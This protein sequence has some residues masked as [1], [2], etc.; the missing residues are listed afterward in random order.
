MPSYRGG[1]MDDVKMKCGLEIHVQ[2]D[3]KSKLFC[4]CPTNYKD[5]PPN[6]NVCPVCMG[7]PGAKPMPPNKKAVDVAIMVA[8]MLGCEI[9]IDKDI[10]FQR[11]HYDYPDLP[12][13]YQRTS[14]PIGVNGNFISILPLYL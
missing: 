14:V 13:G 5:V 1:N 7:L 9:V 3:T 8:K 2:V 6:T 4:R 12:S 11:K 10:Y